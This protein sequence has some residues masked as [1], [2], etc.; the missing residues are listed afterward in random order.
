MPVLLRATGAGRRPSNTHSHA[1]SLLRP[2]SQ[3]TDSSLRVPGRKS[4]QASFAPSVQTGTTVLNP[5]LRRTASTQPPQKRTWRQWFRILYKRY[6]IKYLFP[7]VFIM[8]Y[9]VIG[10]VIFY[11][12]ESS[13]DQ[14][15]KDEQYRIYIRERE[16]LR[17]R[18]DE[19]LTDRAARRRD[20]RRK[21]I[22]DAVEYF[23]EQIGFSVSNESQWNLMSA[24]YYSGTLFTTIGYGDIACVTTA[25]RILTVIYSCIGIPLMLITLNDLGKFL[26][27]N[28]NGCV[29]NIEDFG[30]YLGVLRI[31]GKREQK[32][33]EVDM[34]ERGETGLEVSSLASELGSLPSIGEVEEEEERKQPRMSVKVALGIT[35]GWIFFCSALFRLW[36]DWS[37]GESCYFM[38]ISLSTIGLGD[39]SVAR[40]DMMVLC[41]V[42]V[43]I[44]LSLVSMSINVVQVALEDFYINLMMKVI[45]EYQERMAAGGDHMGASVGMMRMWS[46]N[47]TAKYLMPLLSKEKKRVAMEKVEQ[48]AQAQGLEVPAILTDLDEKTGM[49]KLF[50]LEEQEEGEV[51]S[52][53]LELMVQKQIMQEESAE[54]PIIMAHDAECQTDALE[55]SDKIEQTVDKVLEDTSCQVEE[56]KV[57]SQEMETQTEVEEKCNMEAQTTAVETVDE[58]VLTT[59]SPVLDALCQTESSPTMDQISQTNQADQ[60]DAETATELE[61]KSVRIQTPCPIIE[62]KTIQTEDLEERKSPSKMSSAKKRLRR[63]FAKSRPTKSAVT[64][65]PSMSE[66]KDVSEEENA[67]AE[68]EEVSEESLHW[69]PVSGKSIGVRASKIV[70]GKFV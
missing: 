32:A 27:N 33:D 56:E 69:D 40:R 57:L 2:S 68:E 38:Y 52:P 60:I 8:F 63:A 1:P 35:I 30:T 4:S 31:C 43:I 11:F 23:Q 24:M 41:F 10:S 20:V 22:D 42:F 55:T 25:G 28:I 29:K 19:I 26:Y 21:F 49:P 18:M 12:L 7:L 54:I 14:N 53:E 66:W 6:H 59:M 5:E 48:E 44:G 50:Q 64:D 17:R 36:E 3:G 46:G 62:Q 70:L 45:I 65:T 39:I 58:E 34:V 9:M 13:T 67:L 16:L 37:Y 47:K 15:A 51:P 61:M